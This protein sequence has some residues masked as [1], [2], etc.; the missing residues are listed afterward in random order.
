MLFW[1]MYVFVRP[2]RPH[3]PPLPTIDTGRWPCSLNIHIRIDNVKAMCL[4]WQGRAG[5]AA[6][7]LA[8][9]VRTCQGASLCGGTV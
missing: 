4:Q 8:E 5:D 3:P 7:L 1:C 9:H 6:E 2:S